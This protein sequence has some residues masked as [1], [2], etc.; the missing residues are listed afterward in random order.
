MASDV[1][2]CTKFAECRYFCPMTIGFQ[3]RIHDPES[4]FARRQ[5]ELGDSSF[6][7]SKAR[8][9][10]AVDAANPIR[11]WL[12]FSGTRPSSSIPSSWIEVGFYRESLTT[13]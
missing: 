11:G 7:N 3:R 12:R 13:A 10:V 2:K 4:K 1:K 6:R 9:G 5:A 8:T